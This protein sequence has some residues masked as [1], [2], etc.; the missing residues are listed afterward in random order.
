MYIHLPSRTQCFAFALSLFCS[1]WIISSSSLQAQCTLTTE[2]MIFTDADCGQSNGTA[3]VVMTGAAP[4]SYLWSNGA[5][6]AVVSGLAPGIYT[7]TATDANCS[8]IVTF[9]INSANAPT[10]GTNTTADSCVNTIDDGTIELNITGNSPY[11][12]AWAGPSSGSNT[13]V[14][15][16]DTITNLP[17][18]DY[19]I[20]VTDASGCVA[21]LTTTVAE[22][23][24]LSQNLST[25]TPSCGGANDGSITITPTSGSVPFDYFLNGTLVT[26]TFGPHTFSNLGGGVYITTVSD[27]TGCSFVDT[28]LLNEAGAN[29]LNA[30][31]F[32]ITNVSCPGSYGAIASL[33]CPTC[34]VFDTAGNSLGQLS[35]GVNTLIPGPYEVRFTNLSGCTSFFPFVITSPDLWNLSILATNPGCVAGDIDLTVTGATGPYTY[36]WSS[37]ATSQDLTGV[38]AGNYSLTITDAN[39]CTTTRNNIN[40]PACSSIDTLNVTLFTGT[41]NTTCLDTSA[42]PGTLAAVSDLGC[43]PL[44]NGSITNINNALACV[45]FQANNLP[46]TDTVCIAICDN[47]AFCDTTIIVYTV[48]PAI[49]TAIINV[50][51]QDPVV[52]IDTCP[53]NLQLSGALAS[54]NDLGCDQQNVGTIN[55]NLTTGCVNYTPP[56]AAM[57]SGIRSDTVCVELC[58]VNGF[59][60]TVIYIFNN[61]EPACGNLLPNTPIVQQLTDCSNL[62]ACIPTIPRDS[63]QAGEY[64]FSI[65]GAPYT[66]AFDPCNEVNLLQYP[67]SLAPACT[68]GYEVSWVANGIFYGP[69]TVAG[70]S[71]VLAFMNFNDGNTAWSISSDSSVITGNNTNGNTNYG[72]LNITCI[73]SGTVANIGA[74]LQ[75][76][77]ALGTELTFA[78]QGVYTIEVEG[79][80]NCMDTTT[81][82]IYCATTEQYFDTIQVG[83]SN[84]FCLDTTEVSSVDTIY[85]FCS[86]TSTNSASFIIDQNTACVTYIGDSLGSD[87]GCF[88]VCSANGACDTTYMYID[89]GLPAPIAVDDS[90]EL[91]FGQTAGTIDVCVNDTFNPASYTIIVLTQPSKGTLNQNDCSFT[92]TVNNGQCGEDFFEYIIFNN[93]GAD[94]AT[95]IINTACDPFVVYDGFSPNGDGINDFFVIGTINS[96]PNN[97]VSIFNRWGNKVY[98]Q[99]NYQNDWDGTFNGRD[100]PDDF[101]YVIVYDQSD[102]IL[103]Q[104]WI[105][106]SR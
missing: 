98:E 13:A 93:W 24:S 21:V 35:S 87:I 34:E 86:N 96:F 26:Q 85:N 48:L 42:L 27:Q 9:F 14:P 61:L 28:I 100:L 51:A 19:N 76:V 52:A 90:L 103:V 69:D 30:G 99:R 70:L 6:T 5:T 44:D 67:V 82:T 106:I 55:L 64:V 65:N 7:V 18:G 77:S 37:G 29:A 38:P 54:V 95:V 66:G 10:V 31:D 16:L 23:G 20:T 59:C 39:T 47:N 43:S 73:T 12:L 41:T 25:T 72:N 50:A 88:L 62:K 74:T 102:A 71:G 75:P 56:A 2:S 15:A 78:T 45:D 33:T 17:S 11:T 53:L 1:S 57:N 68:G 104:K 79:P 22:N 8:Q 46:G 80:F 4:L 49:D 81:L 36:N 101:Y 60:D 92:Y 91:V 58:D 84:T 94:T 105:R 89:V 32:S 83:E 63:V 3:E 97:R 40:V